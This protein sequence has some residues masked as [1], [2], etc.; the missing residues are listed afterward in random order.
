[1]LRACSFGTVCWPPAAEPVASMPVVL[2]WSCGAGGLVLGGWIRRPSLS[3]SEEAR[4]RENLITAEV[5]TTPPGV[6]HGGGAEL[7]EQGV[8][9]L[10][11]VIEPQSYGAQRR[12]AVEEACAVLPQT[13]SE[14]GDQRLGGG[15]GA[16]EGTAHWQQRGQG[17]VGTAR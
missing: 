12:S 10:S 3:S 5:V 14:R 9:P 17:R 6:A 15:L 7:P 8:G 4:A 16:A 1:M 11:C 13:I 2:R